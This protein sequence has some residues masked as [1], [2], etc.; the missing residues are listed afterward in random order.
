MVALTTAVMQAPINT[1]EKAIDANSATQFA[2]AYRR[3]TEACN[4]CHRNRNH[5]V[6]VIK[7]PDAA[8]FPDQEFLPSKC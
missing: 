6:V 8:M 5:A 2:E 7:V 4:A 1:L 3:L